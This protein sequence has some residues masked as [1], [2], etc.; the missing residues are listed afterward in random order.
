MLV[1]IPEEQIEEMDLETLK[2][3]LQALEPT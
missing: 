2:A 3:L 1:G